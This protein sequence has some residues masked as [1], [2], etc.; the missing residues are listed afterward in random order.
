VRLLVRASTLIDGTGRDPIERGVV[1]V[2]DGR[3]EWIGAAKDAPKASSEDQIIDAGGCSLIPG[4]ID[5]HCHLFFH[6]KTDHSV[7]GSQESTVLLVARGMA[8]AREWLSSG[9]T[10]VRDLACRD[11]LDVGLRDIIRAG[12]VPGPRIFAHG[13][14]LVMTAGLRPESEDLAITV[15]GPDEARKAARRQLRAGVDGL[16]LF[17]SAGIGGGAGKL[18]GEIGWAQL[19]EEEMRAAVVEAHKA[20]KR[21]AIH[22]ISTDSIKNA[23]RAGTDTVEHG[24]F[25]D[26]EGVDLMKAHGTYLVPTVTAANTLAKEGDLHGY[27]P[28]IGQRAKVAVKAAYESVRLAVD[29]GIKIGAG[30][31]PGAG[32]TLLKECRILEDIGLSPMDVLVSATKRGAEIVGAAD[33][34]GTIEP[35]KV[36]DLVL[37][38]GNPLQNLGALE[39]VRWVVQGGRVVHARE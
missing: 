35:G 15:D 22:A 24:V 6:G 10:T 23:V 9:V 34:L 33:W 36:A 17:G 18:I 5:S 20:S 14:P 39:N 26:E 13:S 21:V 1:V 3:I 37:V 27:P 2:N 11:N 12:I 30:S 16:K 32:D 28:H 4:L 19:T 8:S 29:R 31:D 7:P 38:A 25:L